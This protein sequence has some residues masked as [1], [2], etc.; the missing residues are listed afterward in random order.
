MSW[1]AGQKDVESDRRLELER[2]AG[3]LLTGAKDRETAD[4]A[5]AA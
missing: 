3:E 4:E 5:M 1:I 2:L